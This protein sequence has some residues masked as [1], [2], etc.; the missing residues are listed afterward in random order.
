MNLIIGR[1]NEV[2]LLHRVYNSK[3]AEFVAVYG[4]R[5]IGK[6]HL[7]REFFLPKTDVYFSITGLAMV[8]CGKSV[9]SNVSITGFEG[10]A[11][12]RLR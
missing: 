2:D 7:I 10:N 8:Y 4:R 5:R 9:S 12:P 6:T 1:K 3:Q 11:V